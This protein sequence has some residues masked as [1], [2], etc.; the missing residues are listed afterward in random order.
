MYIMC[1]GTFASLF[2]K[3]VTNTLSSTTRRWLELAFKYTD[4]TDS[5]EVYA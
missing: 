5:W 2:N 4:R 3:P 1:P